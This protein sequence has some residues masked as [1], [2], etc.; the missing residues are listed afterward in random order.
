MARFGLP[1]LLCT[2]AVLSAALLA[3]ELKSKSCS[4]VRRLYVSKGF[5]KN[6]APMHEINGRKS[7]VNQQPLKLGGSTGLTW[8]LC[9]LHGL[10]LG[11]AEMIGVKVTVVIPTF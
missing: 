10:G 11:P 9:A 5:N 7:E 4:E 6:D 2:L 3:A 1:A 8:G